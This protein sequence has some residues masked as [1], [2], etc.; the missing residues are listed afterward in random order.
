MGFVA[1]TDFDVVT[2]LRSTPHLVPSR[3]LRSLPAASDDPFPNVLLVRSTTDDVP[4]G[5]S[6]GTIRPSSIV[7]V[8]RRRVLRE[9]P[10]ELSTTPIHARGFNHHRTSHA[11][12]P[13]S[14]EKPHRSKGWPSF[15]LF[16]PVS[17]LAMA[18][19]GHAARLFEAVHCNL[20]RLTL[21]T[22]GDV[23]LETHRSPS[24]AACAS[25]AT[26]GVPFIGSES[27]G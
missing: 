20:I 2:L 22:A 3:T 24:E 16:A 10:S 19:G 4:I 5:R 18:D 27:V 1:S 12:T 13:R 9:S 6:P 17:S 23:V 11:F 8:I 7:S 21:R 15:S 26:N 14:R 25:F